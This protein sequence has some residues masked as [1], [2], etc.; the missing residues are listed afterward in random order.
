MNVKFLQH[1]DD[2][3]IEQKSVDW[4]GTDFDLSIERDGEG[5]LTIWSFDER[6]GAT[7]G[8]LSKEQTEQL[9]N[10]IQGGNI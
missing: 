1:N 9:I 4:H 3:S 7:T 5:G 2:L 6:S 8:N 10:F